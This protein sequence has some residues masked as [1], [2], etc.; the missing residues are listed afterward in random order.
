MGRPI[1]GRGATGNPANRYQVHSRED[2]DDGWGNLDQPLPALETTLTVDKS[3]TV[4]SYNDSPDV[5]FDRAINPYRG[6]EHG[7]IYCYARPSHA[8][9]G[10][11]PGLEFES[12]L[13]YKPDVADCLRRELAAQKYSCGPIMLGAITDAY[14]PV[15]RELGLTRQVIELLAEC[16]HPLSIVTKSAL[17]ER[18]IDVLAD[19]ARRQL[20]EVCISITTLDKELAR[21]LEPRAAA[22][23]RR[24]QSIERLAS[25]GIPVKV[26]VSP[27]IP[28]LTDPE[29]EQI[30]QQARDAGATGARSTLLRLPLEVAPL[31]SDW[32][33]AHAPGQAQRVLSRIRDTRGGKLY[34]PDF[35]QRMSGSGHYAELLAQRFKKATR[36][37]GYL[38]PEKLDCS[39]F[40]K[41]SA[42]G[43]QM[44]LL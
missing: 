32:L 37:L 44:S 10:H 15:E 2:F 40:N 18:D 33:Q 6:C 28:V 4:I 16:R 8:W 35:A 3:R 29:L 25:A 19:M 5:P 12:N 39:Q 14:Q 7:C 41:P 24:L 20:A 22:P 21:K 27:L 38:E 30:L 42:D 26:L 31:F 17:V 36:S 11:S 34:D 9:L 13:Y 1:K 23:H 43:R